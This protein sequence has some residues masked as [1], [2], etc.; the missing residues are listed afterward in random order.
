MKVRPLCRFL[1]SC[2]RYRHTKGVEIARVGKGQFFGDAFMAK[3]RAEQVSVLK[4][5]EEFIA[6]T[7]SPATP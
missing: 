6:A 5:N 4:T 1:L 7:F 2:S 3:P